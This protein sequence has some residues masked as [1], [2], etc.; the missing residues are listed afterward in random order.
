[1]SYRTSY[2]PKYH[3]F[4]LKEA[5]NREIYTLTIIHL[6][7]SLSVY[8]FYS[9]TSAN[10]K[11]NQIIISVIHLIASLNETKAHQPWRSLGNA[12]MP[13]K[14]N[15]LYRFYEIFCN[16]V[17]IGFSFALPHFDTKRKSISFCCLHFLSVLPLVFFKR[18]YFVLNCVWW[19]K[20]QEG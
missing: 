7:F 3:T 8:R 9:M 15:F 2:I 17:F 11:E 6:L 20:L 4:S 10:N 18:V 12:C 14:S 13:F 1:M 5:T 19:R 16:T